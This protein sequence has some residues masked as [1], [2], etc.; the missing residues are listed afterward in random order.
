MFNYLLLILNFYNMIK[1]LSFLLGATLL[2]ALTTNAQDFGLAS[3]AKTKANDRIV[4]S[5]SMI[6]MRSAKGLLFEDDFSSNDGWALGTSWAIGAA[7]AEPAVDHT[8]TGDNGIMACPLGTDYTNGMSRTEAT[9][10]VIDCSSLIAATLSFW[11][12]SGCESSSWD[13]MGVDVYNGSSWE[14]IWSNSGSFQESAWTYYEFD[15]TAQA[16]GNANFQIRLYL[17][18]TDVSVTYSGWA[19]D[20]LALSFPEDHD[21]GVTTF[22]PTFVVFGNDATPQV[23]VHNFGGN[24]ETAYSVTF[25]IDGTAYSETVNVTNTI[26]IGDDAIVEMPVWSSPAEGSYP[27]TAYVTVA[28]DGFSGNDTLILN[29]EV[30]DVQVAYGFNAYAGTVPLGPLTVTLP[31]GHLTS[32]TENTGLFW[33]G[34]DWADGAWYVVQYSTNIL[35]VVDPVT[36]TP[37]EIDT[38]SGYY[39]TGLAYD[40]TSDIMYVSAWDGAGS[41]LYTVDLATAVT[42]LV[43]TCLAD[44]LIIGLACDD[45]GNLYGIDLIY[46]NL[47]SINKATGAATVIGSLGVDINYAQDIT[48]D[49]DN[50]ILYGTLYSGSGG[51]YEINVTTGAVTLLN[52]FV[53]EVTGFAIPYGA[54]QDY[55]VTFTVTDGSNLLDGAN[56]YINSTTLTTVSG[57]A[58]IDLE[59]GNYNYTVELTG[60]YPESGTVVVDG[61]DVSEDVTLTAVLG[62]DVLNANIGVYPNPSNGIFTIAVDQKY[63]L[64][65][66]TISGEVVYTQELVNN[67]NLVNLDQYAGMY[68]LRLTSSDQTFMSK[69]VIE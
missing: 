26:N 16:A 5:K 20:D 67:K 8:P 54:A 1:K 13:H 6:P 32:I 37:T 56:I 63:T 11:S 2:S 4:D 65:V 24:A 50:D 30:V 36:G 57:V 43:G 69:I 35:L 7:V 66:L 28:S 3:S 52:N 15:V 21:L 49:R 19:I 39:M 64:E 51:L 22:V 34:G 47:L 42:T 31:D 33:A 55:T 53:S 44:G 59:N 58:T 38:M 9:S 48:F 10:P 61:A 17:G 60:F 23:T 18:P 29:I 14:T 25:I 62:I 46:D 27:A 45:A 41:V 40:V 12:F 68:I